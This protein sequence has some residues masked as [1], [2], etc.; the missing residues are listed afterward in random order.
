MMFRQITDILS[1]SD[2]WQ[3]SGKKQLFSVNELLP[4]EI[5]Q[6][7][8]LLKA[9]GLKP[10]HFEMKD[11]SFIVLSDKDCEKLKNAISTL[12]KPFYLFGQ[13]EQ[14]FCSTNLP[15]KK[16]NFN[17]LQ[18]ALCNDVHNE[19]WEFLSRHLWIKLNQNDTFPPK[20]P[21]TFKTARK[22]TI[23]YLNI[24]RNNMGDI[25]S[26][27]RIINELVMLFKDITDSNILPD[28]VID[29]SP[30][31]LKKLR[32]YRTT[33]LMLQNTN[34]I[35]LDNSPNI[36]QKSFSCT[37]IHELRHILQK[38][39]NLM[40]TA[41]DD[42]I[43]SSCQDYIRSFA[44]EIEANTY[45]LLNA[46]KRDAFVDEILRIHR[47]N[48]EDDFI[49]GKI[50]LP[51]GQYK[52]TEQKLAA[53][54]RYIQYET[55]TRFI[56]TI[57]DTYLAKNR[58]SAY[59][60]LKTNDITLSPVQFNE[61]MIKIDY[62]KQLYHKRFIK[63][64]I[65]DI[66][67]GKANNLEES[68]LIEQRWK[69]E[70]GIRM[71]L[72]PTTMF[73]PETSTHIGIYESI[74]GTE[75]GRRYIAKNPQCVYSGVDKSLLER[76]LDYWE[77]NEFERIGHLYESLQKKNP[78][79]PTYSSQLSKDMLPQ[80]SAGKIINA[81]YVMYQNKPLGDVYQSMGYDINDDLSSRN[82]ANQTQKKSSEL[83]LYDEIGRITES[84]T[85]AMNDMVGSVTSTITQSNEATSSCITNN[86]I[87]FRIK[88]EREK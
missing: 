10:C 68:N 45:S 1:Q 41:S 18:F 61:M 43:V 9:I 55:E 37:S 83:Q 5:N 76:V 49:S 3:K 48:V 42:N 67:Y 6:C 84:V 63:K 17:Y 19:D 78:C 60:A 22:N 52:A 13:S 81:I 26:N 31:A 27:N 88:K 50:K 15:E 7:V 72:S 29:L 51:N 11:Q 36:S 14:P 44:V 35:Y 71:C 39:H 24:L 70:T 2:L 69:D 4:D 75:E 62:W 16:D 85:R 57:C 79:L 64:L 21:D 65:P 28:I 80:I 82:T 33:G 47:Q 34:E 32:E 12:N 25:I 20:T 73:T 38:Y 77:K 86:R 74:Y 87:P 8:F 59:H 66:T 30:E 56:Q 46:P 40:N 53:V 54:L 58:L 23:N